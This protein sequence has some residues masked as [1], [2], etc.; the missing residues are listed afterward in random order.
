MLVFCRE[1]RNVNEHYCDVVSNICFE[2]TENAVLLKTTL[3]LATALKPLKCMVVPY[4]V[5][6]LPTK[7]TG[8]PY[9]SDLIIKGESDSADCESICESVEAESLPPV[10]T[11]SRQDLILMLIE[12][13]KTV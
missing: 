12:C 4:H 13:K 7:K 6:E 10:T 5:L 3:M 8:H 9:I 11:V 1:E 2:C